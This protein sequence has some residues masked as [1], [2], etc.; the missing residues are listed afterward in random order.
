M[1]KAGIILTILTLLL[2]SHSISWAWSSPGH[3]AIAAIA[4]RD[5]S[6]TE[7]DKIAEIL[8]H[9]PEYEKWKANYTP[10][11]PNL[12][13][14][15]YVFMRASTWPDEIRRK[16]NPYDHPEWHYIDYP[17]EPP[18]FPDKPSPFPT[19]DILSGIS[20]SSKVIQDPNS[21][22]A[23]R[24]AYFS[25]LIHLVGDIHQQLHCSTLVNTNYRSE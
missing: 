23:A 16:G 3:M 10:D 13:L 20:Q 19:N 17:L 5:L 14:E 9:H 7:K 4:Y 8:R 18:A 6:A 1:K 22:P 11:V 2:F 12:N 21:S 24:G 25:W 15:T